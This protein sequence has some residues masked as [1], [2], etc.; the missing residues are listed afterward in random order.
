[1]STTITT[2][3]RTTAEHL[4]LVTTAHPSLHQHGDETQAV[5]R[6]LGRLLQPRHTSSAE[7]TA[8]A[9]IPW[10]ADNDCFQGL[11]VTAFCR[12]LDRL[13]GL[14]GCRFVTVPDVV[15]DARATAMQFEKWAPALERR[16][17]P[18][19]LVLQNGLDEP[20][21][22]AWL[23]R[24]WHRLDAVFVGG[25]DDFKLGPIAAELAREAKR[26]GKWVHWGRVNS[27]KRMA[28]CISTGACDSMDGSSWARFRK[29]HLD[30]GLRW[31]DELTAE[32]KARDAQI[33]LLEDQFTANEEVVMNETVTPTRVFAQEQAGEDGI[34]IDRTTVTESDPNTGRV[35]RVA[36]VDR[37]REAGR[38]ARTEVRVVEYDERG[39]PSEPVLLAAG[40]E[41][42]SDYAYECREHEAEQIRRELKVET[43]HGYRG[44][45]PAGYYA[46]MRAGAQLP[47]LLSVSYRTPNEARRYFRRDFDAELYFIAHVPEAI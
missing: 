2:P 43:I 31:L 28:Y 15:G 46:A 34:R 3:E 19:A 41:R 8:L 36:V 6:N 24:T 9:G 5:H 16:G 23:D 32:K 17:L 10:A 21:L 14:P 44:K 29:T 22:R 38:Q 35:L 13:A 30:K 4:L 11:D 1:M 18:L 27:R 20:A 12:M 40:D 45:Q 37:I 39:I 33:A 26:R 47:T 25:D 42:A 7:L